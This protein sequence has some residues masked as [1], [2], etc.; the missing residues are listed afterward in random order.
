MTPAL[1]VP[2]RDTALDAT[3]SVAIWLMVT[4][5]VSRL[6][7]KKARPEWMKFGMLIEP[8]CQ[9]LFMSMV[10]VSLVYSLRIAT[11]RGHAGWA[12]RQLRR[13]GELWLI[14][15]VLFFAQ[16]GWQWPW[17]IA[18][19]GILEAIAEA[20]LLFLPVVLLGR[21]RPLRG[22]LVAGALTAVMMATDL[23]L[24]AQDVRILVFNAGNGCIIPYAIPTGFGV[25]AAYS[26]LDG[27]TKAKAG[28][29]LFAGLCAAFTLSQAG[30]EDA[31]GKPFGRV[32]TPANYLIA[33]DGFTQT[34]KLLTDQPLKPYEASYYNFRP[35][36]VPLLFALCTAIYG[37]FALLRPLTERLRPLW[38]V[39]R[40]SLG[41]YVLHLVLVAVPVVVTGEN[42]ALP[43]PW[44]VNTGFVV[45]LA[46]C[47]AYAFW[48][49]RRAR[50]RRVDGAQG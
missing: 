43:E 44:K 24:D 14:G 40:H 39:G 1:A 6:I 42:R 4:C 10:G 9:A 28:L 5:H 13:A 18:A 46:A 7:A 17:T 23:A 19:H 12:R 15:F 22:A 38:V 32:S 31:F 26:L 48:K 21:S 33:G 11:H 37:F 30:F 25:V 36:L 20:M 45:I 35:A 41:V 50:P 8:L 49:D 27:G 2:G 16:R 47:Y 34:W 3:R 29:L